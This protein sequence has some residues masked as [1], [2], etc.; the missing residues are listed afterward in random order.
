M[1]AQVVLTK[2]NKAIDMLYTFKV[3]KKF[4]DAIFVGAKVIVPFG[5]GN[6][7]HEAFV[8]AL[9]ETTDV[10]RLKAIHQL[11]EGL[12]LTPHQIK[13]VEW[14]RHTYL[15][16]YSEAMLAIIPSKTGL[17]KEVNYVWLDGECHV[18]KLQPFFE[19][20][21]A[22]EDVCLKNNIMYEVKKQL[23]SGKVKKEERFKYDLQI[24]YKT[25]VHF[26]EAIGLE[27]ML[28]EIRKNSMNQINVLTFL[29]EVKSCD[30]TILNREL[31]S[32]KKM[33]DKFVDKAWITLEEVEMFRKPEI[34]SK[35]L[36]KRQFDLSVSQNNVYHRVEQCFDQNKRFLLHGVT[37][38]GKTEVYLKLAESIK[39]KGQQI[40][41]L[42]PEIAL[43]PQMVGKFIKRFGDEIA[44]LHSKVTHVERFDQYRAIQSGSVR[45]IIGARSAIFAPCQNLGMII[46]D[47]EHEHTYKSDS[48]PKYSTKELAEWMSDSLNIPMMLASATPDIS[49]YAQAS[50]GYEL[51]ELKERF[52]DRP[53]PPVYVVDM[54]EELNAGN[55]SIFSELL[56]E[57]IQDRLDK[58]EQVI[59]FYNRK[60]FATFVSCRS[61]GYALK[62]PKCD[63]ALTYHHRSNQ[64]KCSY[65][66][67]VIKVPDKCPSCDSRYFKYFGAGTEKVETLLR[68]EFPMARIARMDSESTR[69]KGALENIIQQ[70]EKRE[71]DVLIG[72]QMVTKGLDFENVTLVGT[73]SADLSLNLPDYRA[74]EKT[75]QLLTQVAGRAGR[76][77]KLGEVIVQTYV[78]E[79]YAIAAS[80]KHDY[81]AF[82]K[83]EIKLREAF[84]YPPFKEVVSV[85]VVSENEH[86]T[87]ASAQN[88]GYEIKRFIEKKLGEEVVEILG[89]NP[90]V[91][92]KLNNK[93]RWQIILKFDK[94]NREMV[95]NILH[96]VCIKHKDRVVRHDVYISIN[97]NPMSLL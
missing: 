95:R 52:N 40:I 58:K 37:G 61:C 93:Y 74:P 10:K 11:V 59:L 26:N 19:N 51:L 47:E 81:E 71:I 39:N 79:H 34:L 88:L 64:G 25:I 18:E 38:S 44:I 8:F 94:M 82:F 45:I 57:K 80:V 50:N 27:H 12:Y 20:G 1:F 77:E 17:I 32:T 75:F 54:R 13:L 14:M 22:S 65:C 23:K 9:S 72:T 56:L 3:P 66:D 84:D 30:L 15:C 67:Y 69:L 76:G 85:L 86:N 92:Q 60:G 48:N 55:K 29:S 43:T 53:L 6:I 97:I 2:G 89:P 7:L 42:V 36:E 4:H 49:T 28:K 70:V 16:T 96:Y 73:L 21:F 46:L 5:M 62:C 78:P 35:V 33:I 24:R 31:K 91:F 87:I 90:A 41:I 68:E 63:I 83:E